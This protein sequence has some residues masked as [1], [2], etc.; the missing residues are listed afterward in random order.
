MNQRLIIL[1]L[2]AGVVLVS[3]CTGGGSKNVEDQGGQAVTVDQ[4]EVRPTEIFAGSTVRIRMGV[5][6]SGALPATVKMGDTDGTVDGSRI[7]TNH[8]PDIF[9][10]NDFSASSSNVS[11]TQESYVLEQG[12]NLQMNWELS[13]ST[14]NV[15]LNG[16]RCQ[17]KFQV[18]F[19]YSVEAFKQL[20]VKANSE[21]QGTEELF[22]KSS[23]GPMKIEIETIGSSSQ[24][25]APTFIQGDNAQ[26]LVQLEN[27]NPEESSYTGTVELKPQVMTARN[28]QF[29][30]VN[31]TTER[32]Q[33]AKNIS[34]RMPG[35]DASSISAGDQVRMCPRP[36]DVPLSGNLRIYEGK[37]KVFRCDVNWTLTENGAQV[38]SLRGEV[39]ARAN[40]TYVKDV[41]E[42]TVRVKYRAQQ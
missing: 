4:L 6:N 32:L 10:I 13:Q 31:V 15:P 27:K 42:R 38:P 12:Y 1:S 2:F 33:A 3:G 36:G 25:G 22:A 8:C 19:D 7:L 18:P 20:Q 24:R 16:Y 40:Y 17:M 9:D 26:V 21:V 37:S 23:K 35:L 39:Y 30:K 28:L 34:S 5:T 29:G 41:G 11:R 14:E